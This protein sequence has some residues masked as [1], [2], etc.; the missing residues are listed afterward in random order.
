[1]TFEPQEKI[2]GI[3][4]PLSLI[5]G[6]LLT[7]SAIGAGILISIVGTKAPFYEARAAVQSEISSL[8]DYAQ[9]AG[10]GPTVEQ[11]KTR[12]A[13]PDN[14]Y[15][16]ALHAASDEMVAGN[17]SEWSLSDAR[18]T[19]EDMLLVEV[20]HS[21]VSLPTKSQ[22]PFT[23]HYDI[24][25][26][27]VD[28]GDGFR[29]KVG[30]NVDDLEAA[31]WIASTF[32]WSL[33]GVMSLIILYIFLVSYYLVSGVRRFTQTATEIVDTGDLSLRIPQDSNWDD[34]GRLAKTWNYM[35]G[36]IQSLILQTQA[37]SNN[38]AHD[39]RTP[40][41][42]LRMDLE[43]VEDPEQREELMKEA[44]TLLGMINGLLRLSEIE[45][46]SK[47]SAFQ[48]VAL[49]DLL[50]DVISFYQPVAEDKQI[51]LHLEPTDMSLFGDR[52]LLFQTFM[53]VVDNA[54]KFTP[55][56]GR[57]AV[58]VSETKEHVSVS[59]K[60]SGS[61]I[62]EAEISKVFERFY[63]RD[64]SRGSPGFGLGLSLVAA[65]A[66]LHDASIELT[67]N[68][69]GLCFEISFPKSV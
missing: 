24:M 67:T 53:N 31:I 54:V 12:I 69:P 55:E 58:S 30:R 9:L 43:A 18:T 48:S 50:S 42:R 52:N 51:T 68:D 33:I 32:G 8:Q 37:T 59:V 62:P 7:L 40:L 25:L 6:A 17:L 14:S 63:R 47:R 66:D 20:P 16:Y 3:V 56:A 45:T 57:V 26:E 60:D 23:D 65:I 41:T 27:E 5:F 46:G 21:A 36:E 35:L 38:I 2:R 49:N 22:R 44:D 13:D 39:L 29:L 19:L 64:E 15:F 34:L 10:I 61:G 11:I 28:L 4:A 1:M